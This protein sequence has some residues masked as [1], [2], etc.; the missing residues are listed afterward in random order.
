M[1]D[2]PLITYLNDH[3]GG[4]TAGL[5]LVDR[6]AETAVDLGERT[7]LA[8]LRDE[9]SEDRAL[10]EVLI[11]QAGGSPSALK[12]AGGWLIEKITRLKLALDSP[13]EGTLA[14]FEAL[15]A[16]MLGIHGKRAMWEALGI[17]AGRFPEL[18]QVD[19][20]KLEKRAVEQEA[21]VDMFRL[22]AARAVLA[23][24]TRSL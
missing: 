22:E 3:L 20:Q 18:R 4:S 7:A 9:I 2:H 6:L 11:Q 15:E 19:F 17:A 23:T 1:A 21:R 10:L 12:S 14:R 5:E 24:P 16:L 13:S 8:E